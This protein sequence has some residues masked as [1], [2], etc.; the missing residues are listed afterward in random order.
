MALFS[1][2]AMLSGGYCMTCRKRV[3]FSGRV[4]MAEMIWGTQ[5]P[6]VES[7]IATVLIAAYI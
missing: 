7:S 6:R 2:P 3:P 5:I 4:L 1:K